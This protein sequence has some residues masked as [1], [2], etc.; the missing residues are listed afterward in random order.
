MTQAL[1]AHS[2]VMLGLDPRIHPL[3]EM[4]FFERWIA[5]SSLAMTRNLGRAP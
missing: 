1:S 2:V 5:G 4:H 3:R